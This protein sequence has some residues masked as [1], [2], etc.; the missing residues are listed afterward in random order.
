MTMI[1][2]FKNI[3]EWQVA[4]LTCERVLSECLIHKIVYATSMHL[5]F[6]RDIHQHYHPVASPHH[7]MPGQISVTLLLFYFSTLI[8][9]NKLNI[10]IF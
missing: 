10:K 9:K 7:G 5:I 4:L 8:G 1:L 3:Q 2:V 6:H